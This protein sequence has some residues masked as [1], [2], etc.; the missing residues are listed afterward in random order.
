[1]AITNA[2]FRDV[3]ISLQDRRVRIF[4][5][6][7][8]FVGTLVLI[9]KDF[10]ELRHRDGHRRIFITIKHIVAVEPLVHHHHHHHHHHHDDCD[11]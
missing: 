1:M 7:R 5:K 10:I 8:T 6:K 3:L 2:T 4:T 11:D 9:G